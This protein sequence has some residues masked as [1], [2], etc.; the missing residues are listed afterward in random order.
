MAQGRIPGLTA[1]LRP[2]ECR[3]VRQAAARGGR[4]LW[5][6]ATFWV[7]GQSVVWNGLPRCGVG[8]ELPHARADAGITIEGAHANADRIGVARVVS[9]DRRAAIGAEPLRSAVVGIPSAQTV[10]SRH[11]PKRAGRGVGVSRRCRTAAPLTALAMAV[12]GR[13]EWFGHLVADCSAVA[14]TRKRELAHEGAIVTLAATPCD[15]KIRV[16]ALRDG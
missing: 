4:S 15:V 7:A 3:S 2:A 5:F 6:V 9:V 8:H 13:D 12:A 16:A 10:L 1:V 14:A 11:D